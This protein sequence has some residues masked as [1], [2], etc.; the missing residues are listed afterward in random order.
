MIDWADLEAKNARLNAFVDL[1]RAAA[2]GAGR[3]ADLTIGIK[4]NLA[5]KGLPWTAGMGLRLDIIAP[6]DAAVVAA[7]RAAGAAIL[8]TLNMQ[9]AALGAVTDNA[10]YG[11]THNPHRHGFTPGGSSGGSG[12]AV[13]ARLCDAALGTDT[14]GSIRLPAAYTGVYGLKPTNGAVDTDGLIPLGRRYDCIG[15]LAA[16]LDVLERVWR[17]IGRDAGPGEFTRVVVLDGLAGIA[18]QPGVRA[19]YD[20]ALAALALPRRMLTLA[21]TPTAI[22]MAALAEIGRELAADL[23]EARTTHA[24]LISPELAFILDAIAAAPLAPEVLARTRDAVTGALGDDGVLLLPTAPQAAFAH[25][26]RAPANQADFTALA[27]VAGLPALALPAGLDAD[28]LPIGVQ[29]VGPAGSETR[30]IALARHLE[31]VLG[32]SPTPPG[33]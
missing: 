2:F 20:R 22:R 31:G 13:A 11:R 10:F 24:A 7:V 33:F 6:G 15:P 3:L 1:D 29:I 18:V 12:A 17:V 30:L 14:L 32:G 19:G 28:R 23:G 8:G 5:V 9:E 27:N 16:S 21:D 26:T 25:G 4:A